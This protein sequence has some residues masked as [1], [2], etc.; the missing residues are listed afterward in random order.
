MEKLKQECLINLTAFYDIDGL[1]SQEIQTAYAN[2]P[3][4]TPPI[5]NL[6][7]APVSKTT[8]DPT[9]KDFSLT[10]GKSSL[11]G[12]SYLA[13]AVK[14]KHKKLRA[15]YRDEISFNIS[16][17]EHDIQTIEGS[18]TNYSSGS[19]FT[20]ILP[21]DVLSFGEIELPIP[22]RAFPI[23]PALSRQS[24]A[25]VLEEEGAEGLG[26]NEL[27]EMAKE[28]IYSYE[29]TH[30]FVAQDTLQTQITLNLGLQGDA[31]GLR[32]LA[33]QKDLLS[34]LVDFNVNYP[35]VFKVLEEE[36]P[37][38][39]PG[40]APSSLV[41]NALSSFAFLVSEVAKSDWSVAQKTSLFALDSSLPIRQSMYDIQ[42]GIQLADGSTND[43]FL[44]RV[45][46]VE[47]LSSFL[48]IAPL[49]EIELQL[50]ET[51]S[52]AARQ[53]GEATADERTFE[54]V[55][56]QGNFLRLEEAQA[57]DQRKL[58]LMPLEIID[59]QNGISE[60]RIIRNAHL[61]ADFIY[62]TAFTEFAQKIVPQI[63]VDKPINIA[64]VPSDTGPTAL[65]KHLENL[66][67]KL[68]ERSDENP[69]KQEGSFRIIS[70][71]EFSVVENGSEAFPP[72]RVPILLNLP[73]VLPF[74]P[75]SPAVKAYLQSLA[76]RIEAWLQNNKP[77]QR[78]PGNLHFDVTLFTELSASGE[79]LL[80]LRNLFLPVDRIG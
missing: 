69:S 80:R 75:G 71:Y 38:V 44:T 70:S 26:G 15:E 9:Q 65:L 20:F 25:S 41:V 24:F 21:Q 3:S 30:S 23:P 17:I 45:S 54:Y 14:S 59:S 16:A 62:E 49:P 74:E 8:T 47:R 52:Y 78:T 11:N 13:Y 35:S 56:E 66:F 7:G 46:R 55:D 6:F 18:D 27:I 33:L 22:L 39:K 19:W 5:L 50:G 4:S 61:P 43:R 10:S 76:T 28:W 51:R 1:V 63:D 48:E 34:A 77:D 31:A 36:L 53:I 79:Y 72:M 64:E 73:E 32:N 68:L 12:R 37:K 60:I 67:D 29:F 57:F 40:E 2:L 58:N 42:E